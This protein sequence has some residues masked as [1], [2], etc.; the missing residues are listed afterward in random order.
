MS[1][2]IS[3]QTQANGWWAIV[4]VHWQ[5]C[6]SWRRGN[7]HFQDG[8]NDLYCTPASP[9]KGISILA[10]ATEGKGKRRNEESER[11]WPFLRRHANGCVNQLDDGHIADMTKG[12]AVVSTSETFYNQRTQTKTRTVFTGLQFVFIVLTTAKT[13][14]PNPKG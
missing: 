10:P 2:S 13:A 6:H 1:R 3:I 5:H 12:W 14:Q 7:D 8:R 4:T 11:W 9:L